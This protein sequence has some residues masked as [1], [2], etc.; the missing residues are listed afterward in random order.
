MLRIPLNAET[1]ELILTPRWADLGLPWQ[2]ALLTLLLLVPAGLVVWLYRYE[3]RLVRPAHARGLLATR[4]VVVLHLWIMVALQP[5]LSHHGADATPGRVVVAVDLSASM[6]V[7]DVQRTADE[8]EKLARA[9]GATGTDVAVRS[10]KEIA[11]RLLSS[12]QLD[13][14][15]RIGRHHQV[16]LLGFHETRWEAPAAS[17]DALFAAEQPRGDARHATDLRQ[18]LLPSGSATA[19]AL[20][21]VI[22]I[23]DGRHNC[24]TEPLELARQ[25]G[26]VGVPIYTVAIG[27][28][29]PPPDLIV[30]DVQAPAKVFKD[31]TLPVTALIKVMALPP[32]ELA[33]ELEIDG[34]PAAP[35]H[36][37]KV[38]HGGGD[39]SYEVRFLVPMKLSGTHAI[40]VRA[41]TRNGTEITL[42]NNQR[43]HV[44]LVAEERTRVL[45]VDEEARWEY[46]YLAGALQRDPSVR[47]DRVLFAPPRLG[48][49]KPDDADAAG[50]PRTRLPEPPQDARSSDRLLDYDCIILG[51]VAPDKLPPLDRKRLERYVAER[52][53]TL[54]L[55]AGKHAMPLAYATHAPSE[56]DPLLKM[57][58]VRE[59]RV[60]EKREGFSLRL[61]EA[62]KR[63]PFLRLDTNTGDG[64]WPD[65]PQHFWSIVGKRQPGATVLAAPA[66]DTLDE[67]TGLLVLQSYGFGNVVFVGLDSTWRWRQRIGDAY[68]HR[69]WGQLV[70]WAA[71]DRLLPAGNHLVR[72]GSRKPVY[73]AGEPIELAARLSE[74]APPLQRSEP[75][76]IKIL[77]QAPDQPDTPGAVVPL[78]KS[79]QLDRL[80]EGKLPELPA[81]TY[82]AELDIAELGQTPAAQFTVLPEENR[83]MLDLSTNWDLLRALADQSHGRVFMPADAAEIVELLAQKVHYS[84]RRQESRAWQDAPFVWWTLG[85]LMGLL[86]V[87]WLWR[88]RLDLP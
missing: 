35:E 19:A 62:G 59:P 40:I 1:T 63:T 65:L 36:R 7:V 82:R 33:V 77:R 49:I 57:L 42:D 79:K 29:R 73:Q 53:G 66:T 39:A 13:L 81:G 14:L 17:I 64:A 75:A 45:L 8:V 12:P 55:V 76:R 43:T 23:T 28:H 15:R 60:F 88:K 22:I 26:T 56:S 87:E 18:P 9:L 86:A 84:E 37:E 38:K 24:G 16:E 80:L 52:G 48:L 2:P 5:A 31:T 71:T 74:E 85:V 32:Q 54:V 10:R 21:A 3:L 47:L 50:L 67:Q 58:P 27:S 41:Q 70:R 78:Q 46:H 69:F 11:Q 61:S 34:Q 44:V 6:D 72:F 51:D 20:D 4:L 25:L 83:E 30:Q 68:H